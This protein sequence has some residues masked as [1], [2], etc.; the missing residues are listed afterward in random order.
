MRHVRVSKV[1]NPQPACECS[2]ISLTPLIESYD[3]VI[4]NAPSAE[5]PEQADELGRAMEEEGERSDCSIE[6]EGQ[7]LIPDLTVA[8]P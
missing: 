1:L 7:G 5:T 8:V 3:R 4:S 6:E 2:S